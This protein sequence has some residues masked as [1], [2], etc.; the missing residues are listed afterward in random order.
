MKMDD[1][2]KQPEWIKNL[3]DDDRLA[4]VKAKTGK[5]VFIDTV[6]NFDPESVFIFV[7][8]YDG[9]VKNRKGVPTRYY[10]RSRRPNLILRLPTQEELETIKNQL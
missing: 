8:S 7:L 4:V 3:K 2:S 9:F 6:Y 10:P 5:L 1:P